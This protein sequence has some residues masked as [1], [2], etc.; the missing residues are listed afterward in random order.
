MF[1][2]CLLGCLWGNGGAS[3]TLI[4]W[5]CIYLLRVG[6]FQVR[7]SSQELTSSP[8]KNDP[9]YKNSRFEISETPLK[10]SPLA[11]IQDS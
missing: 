10:S 2:E 8:S 6:K 7:G 5:M 3:L 4:A 11:R 9:K 1:Y